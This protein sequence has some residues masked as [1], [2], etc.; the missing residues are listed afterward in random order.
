MIQ[1]K[2]PESRERAPASSHDLPHLAFDTQLF[3][4]HL[5]KCKNFLNGEV[6]AQLFKAGF[7]TDVRAH[8][9]S[10]TR[11]CEFCGYVINRLQLK[12]VSDG[13]GFGIA[14]EPGLSSMPKGIE[15]V[16]MQDW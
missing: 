1:L 15:D 2:T 12:P 4:T 11:S 14:T 10:V 9:Q 5:A 7:C 3:A 6:L 16:Q 8:I 13:T